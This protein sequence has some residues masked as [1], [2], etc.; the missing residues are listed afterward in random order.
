MVLFSV[1]SV[2]IFIPSSSRFLFGSLRFSLQFLL[3]LL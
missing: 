2:M 1:F 3:S